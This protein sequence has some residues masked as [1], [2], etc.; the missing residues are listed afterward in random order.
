MGEVTTNQESQG[1]DVY[2]E[3][4][5]I[6]RVSLE[7]ATKKDRRTPTEDTTSEMAIRSALAETTSE[8]LRAAIDRLDEKK[9]IVLIYTY[10]LFGNPH[11]SQVQIASRLGLNSPQ[12]VQQLEEKA[13]R[14]L[15]RDRDL[16]EISGEI[17]GDHKGPATTPDLFLA[18]R[19][20]L[21]TL[22]ESVR[23]GQED[24]DKL[25]RE[26]RGKIQEG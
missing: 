18:R 3:D 13:I 10:G 12:R 23:R 16:R 17:S 26:L 2:D 7:Q 24:D 19:A 14:D 5:G 8:T 1:S 6:K 4:A 9:R 11:L 15:G 25:I 21:R 22:R 20:E